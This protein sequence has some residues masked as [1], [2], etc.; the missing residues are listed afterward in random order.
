MATLRSGATP[1]SL[2]L[3]V[4]AL[5]VAYSLKKNCPQLVVNRHVVTGGE[6]VQ[7][8]CRVDVCFRQDI[9]LTHPLEENRIELFPCKRG[10][11][12]GLFR[13]TQ[14][15]CAFRIANPVE[16]AHDEDRAVVFRHRGECAAEDC[17]ALV[18]VHSGGG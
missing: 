4:A 7:P 9:L 12:R 5:D 10:D 11:K 3:K 17:M 2:R 16:V 14:R 6:I 18:P 1:Y 13:E 15:G 8:L